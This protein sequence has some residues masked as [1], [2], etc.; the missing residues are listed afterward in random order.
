MTSEARKRRGAF[1]TPED[2]VASLVQWAVRKSSDLLLD[3]SCGDGRFLA[4][5]RRCVGV[6]QDS[7][8]AAEARKRAPHADVHHRDFFEWA[9]GTDQRFDCAAGNPPFIRYQVFSGATRERALTYCAA[10]GVRFSALTSSWAPFLVAAASLLKPGGRAAFIV[11]AEIG[12]APY[13]GPL[14]EYLV[15]CFAHV[16]VIAVKEKVFPDLSEDVWLLYARGFGTPGTGF[17]LTT[18]D[19]V[20]FSAHPPRRGVFVPTSAW[21]NWNGRLRPFLLKSGILERYRNIADGPAARHLGSLAKVGIGYVTGAND[22]FHLRPSAAMSLG[23][24]GSCLHHAVRNGR[25][26]TAPAVTAEQVSGW[27]AADAPVLLLRLSPQSALPKGVTLYLESADAM[28]AR[29]TYKCRNRDPWYVVPDVHVPDAFL[30]YMS[31][32]GPSLVANQ[33]RCV[34]TNSVH[35]VRLKPGATLPKLVRLWNSPLRELSCELEGHPLGG[36][37]LKIEPREACRILLG[38]PRSWTPED[39]CAASEAVDTLREWRHCD[40]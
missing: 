25:M 1:F 32:R 40:S 23:I 3:P 22:F 17:L 26:L 18:V 24:P 2:A 7:M 29:D 34:G 12:H 36:G 4:L 31:G 9:A 35:T 11:P 38:R 13:A 30:T 5:H 6:E 15:R 19:R 10:Q 37:L 8:S 21:R 28:R 39:D 20:G 14:L 16:Q 27:L 33:A